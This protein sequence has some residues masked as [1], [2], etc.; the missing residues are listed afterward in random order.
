[1]E[2]GQEAATVEGGEDRLQGRISQAHASLAWI[3]S[4]G[5]GAVTAAT[6]LL[7][8]VAVIMVDTTVDTTMGTTT[9]TITDTTVEEVDI[10]AETI[11]EEVD[12]TTEEVDTTVEEVDTT[13]EEVDTTL[14]SSRDVN[15]TTG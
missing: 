9:D 5:V 7:S 3:L 6:A 11:M 4:L 13:V 1:L 15:V 14:C 10:I 8:T 12:T 2:E